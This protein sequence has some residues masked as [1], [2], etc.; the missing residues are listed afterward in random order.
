MIVNLHF[1]WLPENALNMYI[2]SGCQITSYKLFWYLDRNVEMKEGIKRGEINRVQKYKRIGTG[3]Q[4]RGAASCIH[5]SLELPLSNPIIFHL[6]CLLGIERMLVVEANNRSNI[7]FSPHLLQVGQ[8]RAW[9]KGSK[10]TIEIVEVSTLFSSRFLLSQKRRES[11]WA[12]D[13]LI[14]NQNPFMTQKIIS[15]AFGTFE[16]GFPKCETLSK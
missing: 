11:M 2:K 10:E 4:R 1:N 12:A 14:R 7:T 16:Y 6:P 8:L 5:I 13:L 15:K 3:S 9:M